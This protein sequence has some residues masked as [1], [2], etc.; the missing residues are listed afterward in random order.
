MQN[1]TNHKI[2]LKE[3]KNVVVFILILN[4]IVLAVKIFAG[5]AT[6]SLSILG[7][8]AHSTSDALN[9]FVALAILAHAN[10]PADEEHPYGHGKFET[11]GAFG[12][13]AFLAVAAVE[14]IRGSFVRLIHP[15]EL[16]L[17]SKA[18]VFLL[19]FTLIINL[20]VWIYERKKGRELKSSFLIA[21][22]SHTGSDVLITISVL[23]SQYF[24]SRKMFWTDPILAMIIAGF[25][26][27]AG[28]EIVKNTV[29]ILVDERWINAK[30]I[31]TSVM[32][33][34]GVTSCYDIYSRKS[35]DQAYIECKIKVTSKDLKSAHK[36]ADE[37]ENKLK[38]DFGECKI[39][40]HIEP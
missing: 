5:I 3:T 37:V 12:I 4:L 2:N 10:K 32:S 38:S 8:A 7:D 27:K 19:V 24:I 21:D 39:S 1:I 20:F 23:A 35:P 36:I 34:Q 30:E 15:V 29:P 14:I 40:V 33:I 17:F 18:V 28:Y 9:N 16:P 25:I 31:R 11:L 13:V 26:I 6:K 22:S